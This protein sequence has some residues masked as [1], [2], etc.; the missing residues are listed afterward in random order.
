MKNFAPS[1]LMASALLVA[2]PVAATPATAAATSTVHV[3]HQKDSGRTIH[4]TRG[5]KFKV[6]LKACGDCGD[7]W[8]FS[9]RPAKTIVKYLGKTTR[10]TAT[11]P[12]VGGEDIVT[13]T[14]KGVGAGTTKI[15]LAEHAA[16][17]GNKVIKRFSLTVKVS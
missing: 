3:Y 11:P 16:S 1:L 4:I 14:F 8:S 17:Q 9:H 6:R 5:E 7:S 2:A 12:A 15:G 13:W 10:S